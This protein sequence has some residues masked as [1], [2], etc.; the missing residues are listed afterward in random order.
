MDRLTRYSD[1]LFLSFLFLL[2]FQTIYL[3]REP[4]IG[5]EKWQYGT[6]GIYLS[7]VIL[8]CAVTIGAALKL[9]ASKN[10]PIDVRLRKMWRDRKADAFLL[11]F[12]LWSGLSI[13]WAQD[14][15]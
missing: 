2:P 9:K 1:G 6:I 13:I 14:A 3:L 15:V 8:A 10:E 11:L 4:I 7:S 5:G 12:V